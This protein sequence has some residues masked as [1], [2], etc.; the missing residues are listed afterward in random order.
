MD[1]IKLFLFV[2]CLFVDV[3]HFMSCFFSLFL[4]PVIFRPMDIDDF[5]LFDFFPRTNT[6]I[7]SFDDDDVLDQQQQ[8]QK[9]NRIF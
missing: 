3:F 8:Q 5:V 2:V 9:T 6:L 7:L 4:S 1:A